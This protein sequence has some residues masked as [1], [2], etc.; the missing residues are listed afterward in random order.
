MVLGSIFK[1]II[2]FFI[3]S[4][5]SFKA[6]AEDVLDAVSPYLMADEHPIK[7]S[8]DRLFS[9]SRVIL[10]LKTLK[11]AG[12][13]KAKPRKFTDLIVTT[14]PNFPGYIFKLYLDAQRYHKG[15]P[16]HHYWILRIQ[17]A[18]KI[19]KEIAVLGLNNIFKVP[20]KWIYALPTHPK[21]ASG[22]LTKYYILVEED[23]E[24]L[25]SKKNKARWASDNVPQTTLKNL[26]KILKKIGLKDCLKP[27]NI[28]FSKDGRI[29][30][31][32]TQTFDEKV[33]FKRLIPHLSKNNQTYWKSLLEN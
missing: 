26:L 29:A 16:E 3:V 7:A 24:L 18:E 25:S 32:D 2:A 21:I 19:R 8:L 31:I 5:F 4:I 20:K 27:D 22:Y 12:F 6:Y 33:D 13:D 14:H 10:N 15:L 23:M 28:P 17:G 30:F 9:S 1:V 11:K